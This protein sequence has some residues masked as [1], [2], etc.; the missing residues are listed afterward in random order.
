M[1]IRYFFS[2]DLHLIV[3]E[4]FITF[5]SSQD[6][7]LVRLNCRQ[8]TK[9][10]KKLCDSFNSPTFSVSITEEVT[11]SRNALVSGTNEKA[12]SAGDL[13]C[14]LQGLIFCLPL[15]LLDGRESQPYV[16]AVQSL[17]IH[18]AEKVSLAEGQDCFRKLRRG[19]H[20]TLLQNFCLK[21]DCNIK[22]LE[23]F[24]FCHSNLIKSIWQLR[25]L[26]LKKNIQEEAAIAAEE[27][28]AT[29]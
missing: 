28:V 14:L 23:N 22:A 1:S 13:D 2:P 6:G 8:V 21:T 29:C 24:L 11:L 12:I 27:S 25:T 5:A 4:G 10:V 15:M 20:D 18:L 3:Q 16:A 9:F 19:V 17:V 7:L 26:L